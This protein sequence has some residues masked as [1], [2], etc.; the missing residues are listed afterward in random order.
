MYC[1]LLQSIKK[2]FDEADIDI[3]YPQRVV[4]LKN[5]LT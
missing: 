1:D 3:P 4:T 2:R 5:N